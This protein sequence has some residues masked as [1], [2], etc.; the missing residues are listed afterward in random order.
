MK[1]PEEKKKMAKAPTDPTTRGKTASEDRGAGMA[2][3]MIEGEG[4]QDMGDWFE[5]NVGGS[6]QE[7]AR[8]FN[9]SVSTIRRDLDALAARGVVRRTHGG[10]VRI[11]QRAT[12]EP[13][14]DEA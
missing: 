11:R 1:M 2:G 7:L 4:Q 12:Y 5:G 10:A 14:I 8:I 6:N 3:G 13:S 9:A